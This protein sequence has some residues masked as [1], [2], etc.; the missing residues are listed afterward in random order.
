MGAR[1]FVL[2]KLRELIPASVP[3]VDVSRPERSSPAEGYHAAHRTQQQS[4]VAEAFGE[5][6]KGSS[7]RGQK[8][9]GRART[10]RKDS[11]A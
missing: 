7:A 4:I 5:R 6:L 10:S 9:R 1:K 11:T 2:P 3:I 8:G